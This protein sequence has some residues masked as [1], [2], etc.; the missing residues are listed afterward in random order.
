MAGFAIFRAGLSCVGSVG[1]QS[2]PI[3]LKLGTIDDIP[4][5]Y[6]PTKFQ[7]KR[8]TRCAAATAGAADF[9]AGL[10]CN[11]VRIETN[12]LAIWHGCSIGPIRE[13]H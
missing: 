1:L 2:E 9:R 3:G 13:T 10:N 8:I 6:L 12:R 7:A 4:K 5:T 11:P